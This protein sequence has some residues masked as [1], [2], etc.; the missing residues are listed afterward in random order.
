MVDGLSVE[1]M[2]KI[3]WRANVDTLANSFDA[4]WDKLVHI[5]DPFLLCVVS[6]GGHV[7]DVSFFPKAWRVFPA[8]TRVHHVSCSIQRTRIARNG[9]CR[10][11]VTSHLK[12]SNA[13]C[14]NTRE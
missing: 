2:H 14:K 13:C 9:R 10:G 11:S 3:C 1:G 7:F 8:L 12:Y 5:K 4:M 6:K